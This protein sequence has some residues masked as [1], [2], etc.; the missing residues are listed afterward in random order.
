MTEDINSL[1]YIVYDDFDCLMFLIDRLLL[2][3][4]YLKIELQ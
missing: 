4:L 3:K 1:Y 2:M